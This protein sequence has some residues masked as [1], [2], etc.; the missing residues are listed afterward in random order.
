[1]DLFQQSIVPATIGS[2]DEAFGP[3][4]KGL[5]NQWQHADE[6]EEVQEES[7]P[8]MTARRATKTA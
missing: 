7:V 2:N 6:E 1:L 5:M 8:S 4:P 3:M